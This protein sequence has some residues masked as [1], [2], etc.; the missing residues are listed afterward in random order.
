MNYERIIKEYTGE[1][2]KPDEDFIITKKGETITIKKWE[3]TLSA[4]PTESEINATWDNIKDQVNKE[5]QA[6][7]IDINLYK[8]TQNGID[9]NGKIIPSSDFWVI[10]YQA[11]QKKKDDGD[12]FSYEFVTVDCADTFT[13]NETNIDALLNLVYRERYKKI[14]LAEDAKL[15]L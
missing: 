15:A 7:V 10:N 8:E 12:T 14:R 1:D 2:L 9:Y 13:I 3:N 5:A 6:K 11:L 4:E